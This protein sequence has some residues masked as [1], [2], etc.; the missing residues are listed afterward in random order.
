MNGA[1]L[2]NALVT[3]ETMMLRVPVLTYPEAI[4]E[5]ISDTY[6]SADGAGTVLSQ[7]LGEQER[8]V[9]YF[10]KTFSN[11]HCN[12]CVTSKELLTVELQI[13]V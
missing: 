8:V 1:S 12:Y 7:C 10:S 2:K 11:P 13:L 5:Y 9:G 4:T 3:L 6:V